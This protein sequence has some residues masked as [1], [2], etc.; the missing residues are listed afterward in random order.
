MVGSSVVTTDMSE[1][2]RMIVEGAAGAICP[3]DF[4]EFSA[5]STPSGLATKFTSWSAGNVRWARSLPSEIR[6]TQYSDGLCM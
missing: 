4:A 3:L 1:T 6:N 5:I 2:R